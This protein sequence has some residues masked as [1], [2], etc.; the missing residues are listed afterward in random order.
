MDEE[1]LPHKVAVELSKDNMHEIKKVSD[2]VV[3]NAP[4]KGRVQEIF[5]QVI[6]IITDKIGPDEALD[7]F[8]DG[9][10]TNYFYLLAS[11][12]EYEEFFELFDQNVPIDYESVLYKAVELQDTTTIL[13]LVQMEPAL[14]NIKLRS[15]FSKRNMLDFLLIQ[16]W[17][18]D[19]NQK[20]KETHI[21]SKR[22]PD[23]PVEEPRLEK[24]KS[25]VNETIRRK[26]A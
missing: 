1:N 4:L 18:V 12:K 9:I 25:S 13:H 24:V 26:A 14:L 19:F 6:T 21:P 2:E 22:E 5:C 16:G 17:G 20:L 11:S 3:K 23:L 7:S 15:T 10:I 8:S